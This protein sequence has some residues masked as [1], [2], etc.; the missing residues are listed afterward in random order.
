MYKFI[1]LMILTIALVP[2]FLYAGFVE[3]MPTTITQPDGSTLEAFVTGDEYYRRVHDDNGYTLVLHP[4]TG[5]AVYAIP[6]GDSIKESDYI[7]GRFDPATLG[8]V[9]HLFK[10]DPAIDRLREEQ[11]AN[12][13]AGNRGSPVGTL[14]NIIGFVRFSDQTEFPN[15][16]SFNFYNDMFNSTSDRSLKDYYTEVSSGQLT[17]NS[18][19]YPPPQT[20]GF[21]LSIQADNPRNYYSPYNATTN[22]TGYNDENEMWSR[23]YDLTG[24]LIEKIEPYIPTMDLDNDNDGILDALTFVFRGDVDG[25]GNILWPTHWSFGN[26]VGTIN[27]I[28]VT[29]CVYNFEERIGVRVVC[30]EMGHMIGFPDFYHYSNEWPWNTIAPVAGWCLMASGNNNHSLVYNKWKY[31]TWFTE[32]PVIAPTSTPTTYTLPAVDISPYAAYKI[33]STNPDQY[34][35]V[36]YRRQTG[37]YEIGNPNSGLIVYR[38]ISSYGGQP[39]NGNK[40]GPPDEVYV[41]RVDGT[42][43]TNGTPDAAAYPT[44]QGRTAIHN[45]MNPKPWLYYDNN[46][47]PDGSLI[48]TDIGPA[49]GETISFVLRDVIPHYWIGF[50][51]SDWHNPNNW[52]PETV[53]TGNDNIIIHGSPWYDPIISEG[54]AYC[55]DITIMD[56]AVLTIQNYYLSASGDMTVKNQINLVNADSDIFVHGDLVW[57]DGSSVYIFNPGAAIN[58]Y[59]DLIVQPGSLFHMHNGTLQFYG[60]DPS[61]LI[62]K[63]PGRII[64]NLHSSKSSPGTLT[65]SSETLHPFNI[66]GNLV[67]SSTSVTNNNFGGTVTLLGNLSDLNNNSGIQ[68]NTGT[69]KMSGDNQ[70]IYLAG[71]NA[72]FHHLEINP[73][74]SVILNSNL[75]ITGN[76]IIWSGVLYPVSYTIKLSGHWDNTIGSAAFNEANSKVIFTGTTDSYCYNE[77]FNELE[78]GK[79]GYGQLII[80]YGNTVT[81]NSY[82]WSGGVLTVNGGTFTALDMADP[83]IRGIIN[84]NSGFIHLHQESSQYLDLRATLNITGGELHLYGG[85]GDSWWPYDGY[86]AL[87]MQDGLIDVHD[88]G[89]FIASAETFNTNITGG[90]IR[91]SRNFSCHR[92]DFNPSGGTIELYSSIDAQLNMTV[93]T[94][95]NLKIN[96]TDRSIDNGPVTRSDIIRRDRE[97]NIIRETRANTVRLM[98]NLTANNNLTLEDG[99]LW[100]WGREANI[101]N[102]IF[103][104][105]QLRM[106]DPLDKIISGGNFFWYDGSEA[107]ITAGTIECNSYWSV[108]NGANVVLPAIVTT[109]LKSPWS[110]SILLGDTST[111]FGNLIIGDGTTGGTY[112]THNSSTTDLWV[113]GNLTIAANN[114]LDLGNKDLYVLGNLDLDGKLDIHTTTAMIQG[115]PDFAPTSLLAINSG[116]FYYFDSTLPRTNYLRGTLNINSGNFEAWYNTLEVEAGSLTT[117]NSGTLKCNGINAVHPNTFQPAGGT[118]IFN[119][120]LSGGNY[121]LNISNGNWLPNLIIDSD[122]TGFFLANDLIIKG[123]LTI[124]SGNLDVSPSNYSIVI[125]GNWTNNI[126]STAFNERNGLVVFNGSSLQSIN[127]NEEFYNLTLNKTSFPYFIMSDS[128]VMHIHNHLLIDNGTLVLAEDN[129]LITYHLT[130]SS[131][132]GLNTYY[133]NESYIVVNGNW[134]DNNSTSSNETGFFY[135]QSTVI[136]NGTSNQSVIRTGAPLEFYNLIIEKPA[137]SYCFINNPVEVHGSF[138]LNGG[139]WH[140][141]GN[142]FNHHFYNNFTVNPNGGFNSNTQNSVHFNGAEDQ[143]ITYNGTSGNFYDVIIDKS[144][145]RTD[146]DDGTL[147]YQRVS[148]GSS[149]PLMNEGNLTIETGFLDSNGHNIICTGNLNINNGAILQLDAGSTLYMGNFKSLNVN[150]GGRLEVYGSS[151]IPATVTSFFGYYD[152]NVELNGTIAATQGLFEYMTSNGLHVKSGATIDPVFSLGNSSFRN[153]SI[154]GTLLTINNSDVVTIPLAHFPTN[155]WGGLSNVSKTVNQGSVSFIQ[156]YGD[157]SGEAFDNDTYNRIIWSDAGFIDIQIV[158]AEWSNPIPY[159]GDSSTLTVTILNSGSSNISAIIYLHLYYDLDDPPAPFSNGDENRMIRAMAPGELITHNFTIEHGIPEEWNTWLYLDPDQLVDDIDTSNNI[160]GP[161]PI[162]WLGLP[163]ITDLNIEYLSATN[164]IHLSWTYPTSADNFKIYR[165]TDPYFTPSEDNLIIRPPSNQTEYTETVSGPF[166]FYRV[167]AERYLDRPANGNFIMGE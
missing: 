64:N 136:F 22:P 120:N 92:N 72:H 83:W 165:S 15:T 77:V 155:T 156:S 157:F 80:P 63:S 99:T 43:H 149:L 104:Y 158:S 161:V 123:S 26:I 154:D 96:K 90:T 62:I 153:G 57:E 128:V 150:G 73:S 101:T 74:D 47:T 61:Q 2:F 94:L 126:G 89:I 50:Y 148:L 42:I 145:S 16:T 100:L 147:R 12:R 33:E 20:G 19:L 65:I 116:N 44:P 152:F 48:I 17:V 127:S 124:A 142:Y 143:V 59:R 84:L 131:M 140:D 78:L 79:A 55:K 109:H 115:K 93:G 164:S 1:L 70:T 39:I 133:S 23:L 30:H 67:N 3:N 141:T 7:A 139:L 45:Y 114:E 24:E 138:E 54:N 159:F 52:K 13:D 97:G 88:N 125:G 85:N 105:D 82:K 8:I 151:G 53:P 60:S 106:W 32:I 86:A 58:C 71:T 76:L 31:G 9:P 27:G 162:T 163:M 111:Q 6:E 146:T 130:I 113:T 118:V 121:A 34:Y 95:Y 49:G 38:I 98:S 129:Y 29:H 112:T 36:E 167:S 28:D 107:Q 51:S 35:V 69:L 14:N 21:V 75:T 110:R 56:D 166:F 81:S 46:S 66:N 122:P 11:Q 144:V 25:W 137:S 10:K 103:I 108:Y 134:I 132:A 4:K 5:Y 87:N 102:D 18:H 117:I 37:R 135:D 41:Y 160:F 40:N 119:T 91:T 68:W